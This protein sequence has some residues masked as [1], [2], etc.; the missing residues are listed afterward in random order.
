LNSG[1]ASVIIAGLTPLIVL[2]ILLAEIGYHAFAW[3]PPVLWTNVLGTGV[4]TNVVADSNGVYAGG[5][6]GAHLFLSRYDL[7]GQRVWR[8]DFGVSTIDEIQGIALGANSAYAGGVLNQTGFIRKYDPNGNVLWS[9][10]YGGQFS[11]P[12]AIL[13][14]GTGGVF[15]SYYDSPTK[16]SVLRTYD[17]NGNSLW[18]DSLG[19]NTGIISMS[20]YS[21]DS[22]VYVVGEN[23]SYFLRSY[24]SDGTLN[25]AKNLTCS[26]APNGVAVD[27]SSIYVV[28][29]SAQSLGLG[30][31][32]AEYDL[33]GTQVWVKNFVSPDGTTVGTPRIS[34]DSS[35]IYIAITTSFS[36]YLIRYDSNGSQVWSVGVPGS[37]SAISARPDGVYVGGGTPTNALLSKYAQSS[38]LVLFGVN[39]PFSF[40]LVGVLAGIVALS[41]FW[42]RMLRKNRIRRPKSAVP[43]TQPKSGEDDSKWIRRPP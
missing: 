38:S 14:A 18:T 24:N 15:V 23:V 31:T 6:V 41:L 29:T 33:S 5:S 22:H 34:V 7:G 1:F 9:S 27:A 43:Y 42:L 40:A 36:G 16:S 20:S 19:N 26:C 11:N 12:G 30:G 13:S 17:S 37:A 8:Q 4:A 35:G 10:Q 25:W 21:G 3:Q 39:P 32:L 28:G 2:T